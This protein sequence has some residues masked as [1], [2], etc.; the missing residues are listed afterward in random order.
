MKTIAKQK[1]MTLVEILVAASISLIVVTVGL[2]FVIQT[3]KAYQYET[4]KLLINRDIR[5]FTIQMIDDATY[6]NNFQI[7]DQISNLS[8]TGY[9]AAGSSTD[10]TNPGYQGYTAD[11]AVTLP[12]NPVSTAT[13][14]TAKL[15]S[16][17]PGDVLVLVY[18]VNGDN[19]KI[20]Q[21]IV[22]YRVNSTP[23]GGTTGTNSTT[24]SNR[25]VAL[26]RLVVAI[27]AAVQ[28]AGIMKL[29]PELTAATNGTSIFPY[30]DGQASDLVPTASVNRGNKM[31]YNFNDTSI[32]VRGRIY[33]NYTAQRIV[34]STYNFTVTPRG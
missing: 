27:P 23:A 5:K 31:F 29:L 13:P 32:L 2:S 12:A 30:V 21:L 28:S 17:M 26:K 14:G 24:V 9:T 20:W 34:K 18:Y 3:L 11:L 22:Y 6:A 7:Y 16:G 1:G 25:T 8:R 10:P 19:T 4:G 15:D 33:E